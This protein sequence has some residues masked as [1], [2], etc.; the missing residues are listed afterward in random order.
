MGSVGLSILC[1]GIFS[2][3][4]FQELKRKSAVSNI[5]GKFRLN[6]KIVNEE[7]NSIILSISLEELKQIDRVIAVAGG[8]NKIESI[9]GAL[10]TG[11][12]DILV[13]DEDTAI[14]VL[15]LKNELGS[16]G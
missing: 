1:P 6:G 5:L 10:N 15:K 2:I 9:L 11:A 3:D 14:K 12:I 16:S 13:T 7:M 4:E 8:E